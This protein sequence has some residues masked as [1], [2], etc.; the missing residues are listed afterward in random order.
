[1]LEWENPVWLLF[2]IPCGIL[3]FFYIKNFKSDRQKIFIGLFRGLV[4]MLIILALANPSLHLP[5]RNKEI[6]FLVD[7][8]KSVVDKEEEILSWIKNSLDKNLPVIL[9]PSLLLVVT[10]KHYSL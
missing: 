4:F 2:F 7:A 5:S 8:S 9:L 10:R 1:M 6:V 3:V